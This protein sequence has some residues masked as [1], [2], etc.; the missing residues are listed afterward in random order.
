MFFKGF[1]KKFFICLFVF[2]IFINTFNVFSD[3]QNKHATINAFKKYPHALGAFYGELSGYGLSY[4]QWFDRF[5]FETALGGYYTPPD[6]PTSTDAKSDILQYSVGFQVQYVVF[7]GNMIEQFSNWLDAALYIFSGVVHNGTVSVQCKENPNYDSNNP[8]EP[9]YIE[10]PNAS[11]L[12]T[13]QL[14]TGFG[15]G[16]EIVLFK[17][18]SIPTEFGLDSIWAPG[19]FWPVKAGFIVQSGFRYR[20]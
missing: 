8:S 19:S 15:I 20:Y 1:S 3:Q 2:L 7:S 16:I 11:P 18:F 9:Q 14:G 17:H 5:G 6:C 4:Q 13:P 12:Y 10:D